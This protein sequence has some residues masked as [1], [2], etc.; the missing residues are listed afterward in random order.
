MSRFF[1]CTSYKK[2]I[3]LHR[4]F[5]N[6]VAMKKLIFLSLF[7]LSACAS[8]KAPLYTNEYGYG[9]Y[10]ATAETLG[11][12]YKKAYQKCPNGFEKLDRI[13]NPKADEPVELVYECK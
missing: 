7:F 4:L 9:V 6:G 5:F 2:M 3:F 13:V 11:E 1:S 10:S 12:C 8:D